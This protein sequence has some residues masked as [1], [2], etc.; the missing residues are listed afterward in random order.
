MHPD[1]I[2]ARRALRR[3]V[4]RAGF[5]PGAVNIILRKWGGGFAEML[6]D[7]SRRKDVEMAA[8]RKKTS[9]NRRRQLGIAERPEPP[10]DETGARPPAPPFEEPG[11]EDPEIDLVMECVG[12]YG[13]PEFV[14]KRRLGK[15]I[16]KR[17][18]ALE[19]SGHLEYDRDVGVWSWTKRTKQWRS[20]YARMAA[21]LASLLT[22][23]ELVEL[24]RLIDGDSKNELGLY[25]DE[26]AAKVA[27][28][29]FDD[30]KARWKI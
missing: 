18:R 9:F 7:R 20:P 25:V 21:K 22:K 6:D 4:Q 5:S 23:D 1:T 17:L 30:G 26:E 12:C 15:G 2:E 24:A 3:F 8:K 27:P 19:R 29:L 16:V 13:V 11:E 14:I 10:K 28:E